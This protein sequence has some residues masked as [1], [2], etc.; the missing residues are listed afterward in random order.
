M[1]FCV[2][3]EFEG[4]LLR[5]FLTQNLRLSRAL[6][7]DLKTTGGITVCGE[8]VTVRRVL[9]AGDVVSLTLPP[10]ESDLT[11]TDLPLSI[12]YE[13]D[14][15]IV[16]DKPPYM[17]THESFRHRGDTLANALKFEFD[18]RGVPF[19]FRAIGRLDCDT[20]GVLL[21]AKNRLSAE[22]FNA[23]HLC[24]GY[25]KVYLA[26]T[27]GAPPTDEG[28][29]EGYIRRTH[30]SM[31]L[32]EMACT[33]KD[34][35]YARTDYRVLDR[36]AEFALVECR[37]RTGRTHQIR[38]QMSAIGHP[39]LGDDL[40][41]GKKLLPRQALH[42][43]SLAFVHPQSGAHVRITSPLCADMADFIRKVKEFD[44]E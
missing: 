32:R 24:G 30:E 3:T 4:K 23:L 21:V 18:K 44:H 12:L 19:V 5:D 10:E 31:I 11:G 36:F 33:G 37:P 22:R 8:T 16:P 20:S 1:D 2:G 26:I 27:H 9:H 7:C 38:V 35:E 29:V 42:A 41:G 25:E 43:S 6:L 28:T 17:P 39:L 40:Y 13:D 34:S 14:W 15:L